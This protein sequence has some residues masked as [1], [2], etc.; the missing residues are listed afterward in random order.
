MIFGCSGSQ[1]SLEC[2]NWLSY[3]FPCA[4]N[5][6]TLVLHPPSW[7][8]I[9]ALFL[10]IRTL[11]ILLEGL[12]EPK[13]PQVLPTTPKEMGIL[14]LHAPTLP[15]GNARGARVSGSPQRGGQEA[16]YYT[17]ALLSLHM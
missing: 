4:N 10:E 1:E 3:Q 9:C 2:G 15:M 13:V 12:E 7:L 11:L 14:H 5:L 8:K 6:L 17:W 16:D